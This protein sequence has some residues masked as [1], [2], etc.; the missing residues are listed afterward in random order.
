MSP[1]H[2]I[3]PYYI[4]KSQLLQSA[5]TI[6][7]LANQ[8]SVIPNYHCFSPVMLQIILTQNMFHHEN[9]STWKA[10][11]RVIWAGFETIDN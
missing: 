6:I 4:A 8:I 2:D 7:K 10:H 5:I 9:T 11:D 1:I 3:K